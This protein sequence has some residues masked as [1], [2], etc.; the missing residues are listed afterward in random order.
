MATISITIPDEALER[1]IDGI[2]GQYGYEATFPD[3]ENSRKRIPNPETKAKF[4]KRMAAKWAK[5]AVKSWEQRTAADAARIFS[6]SLQR[7]C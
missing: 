1:V 3:P 6:E 4:C 5:E 2:A 7:C